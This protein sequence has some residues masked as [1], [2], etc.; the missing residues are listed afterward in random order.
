MGAQAAYR[1]GYQVGTAGG[2]LA[3][4]P[5]YAGSSEGYNWNDG[6]ADGNADRRAELEAEHAAQQRR[7]GRAA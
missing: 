5:Y 3:E 2:G 6:N 7:E 1:E 4:N